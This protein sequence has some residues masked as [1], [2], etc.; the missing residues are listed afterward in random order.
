VVVSL[1][2]LVALLWALARMVTGR[3][4]PVTEA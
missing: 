3:T 2:L 4:V 1:V